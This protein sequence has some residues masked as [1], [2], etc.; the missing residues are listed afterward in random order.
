M[1]TR[2]AMVVLVLLAAGSAC[3]ESLSPDAARRFVA[4]KLFVF[5]CFDGSRGAGR[6]YGDGSVTG[7]IQFRGAGPERT[8]SLQAGTL[9]VRGEAVCASLQGMPFE[10]CFH[11]EKTDDRS[12]RG[13]WMG[14]AYCDFTR[15]S[16]PRCLRRSGASVSTRSARQRLVTS[17]TRGNA[18]GGTIAYSEGGLGRPVEAGKG[19]SRRDL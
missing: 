11:I 5:N 14:F 19:Q 17:I 4:G 8:V 13:S 18:G 7:T 1:V 10:P 15:Q 2:L 6:I 9:R 12:F 16:E 3:A